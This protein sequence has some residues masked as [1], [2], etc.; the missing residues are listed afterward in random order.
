MIA[1]NLESSTGAEK[2]KNNEMAQ[3]P[4]ENISCQSINMAS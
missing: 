3:W 2:K 4:G 1:E